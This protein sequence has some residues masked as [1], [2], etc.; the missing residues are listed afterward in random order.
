MA[1]VDFIRLSYVFPILG[2]YTD[3]K[4]MK[5]MEGDYGQNCER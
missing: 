4:A 5:S 1:L 2:T 3:S